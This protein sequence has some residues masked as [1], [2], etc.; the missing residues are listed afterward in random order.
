MKSVC[1]VN[2]LTYHHDIIIVE[3]GVVFFDKKVLDKPIL[4]PYLAH[5]V[6][7]TSSIETY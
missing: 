4:V 6:T 5:D 2:L 1:G 3:F 7:R